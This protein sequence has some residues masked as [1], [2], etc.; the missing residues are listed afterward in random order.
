MPKEW[1]TIVKGDDRKDG[2]MGI[3]I[4]L[5]DRRRKPGTEAEQQDEKGADR[6]DKGQR[7]M[8]RKKASE[9]VVST[10]ILV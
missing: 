8:L 1:T 10:H 6:K 9:K 7:R 3:G 5:E 2:L 4:K